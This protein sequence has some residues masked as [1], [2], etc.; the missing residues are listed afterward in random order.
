MEEKREEGRKEKQKWREIKE[1]G[2]KDRKME[3][4][5]EK[6]KGY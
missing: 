1:K 2:S 3:E 6:G 4:E 5:K